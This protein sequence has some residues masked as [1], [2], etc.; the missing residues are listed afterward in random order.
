MKMNVSWMTSELKICLGKV[1]LIQFM[2]ESK[3]EL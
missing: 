2:E 1:D 3:L